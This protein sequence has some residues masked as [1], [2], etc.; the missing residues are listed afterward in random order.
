[1]TSPHPYGWG[2]YQDAFTKR[3]LPQVEQVLVEDN[4]KFLGWQVT[5]AIPEYDACIDLGHNESKNGP[6]HFAQHNPRGSDTTF[7]CTASTGRSI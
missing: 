6:R 3:V 4:Y 7:W 5:R 1:M 2:P